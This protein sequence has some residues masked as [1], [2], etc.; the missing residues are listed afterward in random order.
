MLTIMSMIASL[1]HLNRSVL[2]LGDQ[3]LNMTIL[4]RALAI[5]K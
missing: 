5:L 2:I 4:C 1:G 3:G